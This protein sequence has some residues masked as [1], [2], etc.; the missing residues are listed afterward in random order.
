MRKTTKTEKALIAIV[1]LL[2]ISLISTVMLLLKPAERQTVSLNPTPIPQKEKNPAS[3][4]VPGYEGLELKADQLEQEISLKNPAQND[5][6]FII[7]LYLEDGTLLWQS[8]RIDPGEVSAP[9]VLLQPL[10]AGTYPNAVLSY[11]CFRLDDHSQI[12]G[13]NTKLTLRVK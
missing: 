8:E 1:L 4:A 12:N 13:A 9:I 2:T 10:E 7:E 5:C 6:Y 3:I 11:S